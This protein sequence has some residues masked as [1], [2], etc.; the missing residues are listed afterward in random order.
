MKLDRNIVGN[1]GRGKYAIIKLRELDTYTEQGAFGEVSKPIADAIKT[2]EEA[3]ILDWGLEGSEGEFFL[4][5]LKDKYARTALLAYAIGARVD[6]N[7]YADEI[8]SMA[9]RAGPRSLFCKRP[10]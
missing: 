5:R 3:G 4:I 10:D 1:G 7:E 9:E 8:A 6:D 2:L